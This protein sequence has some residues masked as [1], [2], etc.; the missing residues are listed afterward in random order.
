MGMRLWLNALLISVALATPVAFAVTPVF[1]IN[2]FY[3][4]D[5]FTYSSADS[6]Y[7]RTFYDFM[8][9]FGLTKKR[10]FV[11][12]W[13]YDS[14]TFSDNPGAETSLKITDMGP[15]FVYYFDKDRTWVVA[16]TYNLITKGTYSS[17][18]T[19]SELRG[20]SMKAEAGYLPMMWE[21]VFMGAKLNYY[22]ATFNEEITNTTTLTPVSNSRTVI[23]PSF[24]MTIRWD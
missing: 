24:S 23:Y 21:N 11:L 13:N 4:T 10:S 15:K 9:G 3:F 6:A 12:G 14:M 8:A 1:D 2:V 18:A 19:T 7:K 20:S 22:K 16:F 17:G 5:T